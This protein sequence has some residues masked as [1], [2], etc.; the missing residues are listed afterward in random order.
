MRQLQVVQDWGKHF[1]YLQNLG[2]FTKVNLRRGS[3]YNVSLREWNKV[4]HEHGSMDV[5]NDSSDNEAPLWTFASTNKKL[6]KRFLLRKE[7]CINERKIDDTR[8]IPRKF[9]DEDFEPYRWSQILFT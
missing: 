6:P 7:D 1:L 4:H 5:S 9:N 2:N 3:Y 8:F